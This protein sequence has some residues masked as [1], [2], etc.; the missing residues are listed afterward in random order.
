MMMQNRMQK[1]MTRQ[2]PR[3]SAKTRLWLMLAGILLLAAM[4][5]CLKMVTANKETSRGTLVE[6]CICVEEAAV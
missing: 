5:Y 2:L 1:K 3:Q 6:H 4:W